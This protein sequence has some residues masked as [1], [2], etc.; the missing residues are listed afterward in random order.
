METIAQVGPP[1]SG[2]S[3]SAP[4][5]QVFVDSLRSISAARTIET[6]NLRAERDSYRELLAAALEQMQ[7]L[8][9]TLD[10]ERTSRLWLLEQYRAL[11]PGGTA[12]SRQVIESD[13]P[14]EHQAAA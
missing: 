9:R 10:R 4:L 11:L 13:A 8:N 5:A 14:L 6:A 2:P 7:A 3:K 12:A 1:Q